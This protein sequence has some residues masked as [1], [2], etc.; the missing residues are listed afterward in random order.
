MRNGNRR[1]LLR[2]KP[3]R[4][5]P[6]PPLTIT[7]FPIRWSQRCPIAVSS[8]RWKP[9]VLCSMYGYWLSLIETLGW[10]GIDILTRIR[11]RPSTRISSFHQMLDGL[12]RAWLEIVSIDVVFGE[13]KRRPQHDLR[14]PDFDRAQSSGLKCPRA[15]RE[16]LIRRECSGVDRQIPQIASV[17]QDDRLHDAAV[18]VWL[19]DVRQ[20]QSDHAHVGAAGLTYGFGCPGN[21]RRRNRHHQLHRRIDLEDGLRFGKRLVAV[22]VARTDDGELQALVSGGE[23]LADEGD[24]L[25]LVGG[26]ERA[27]DDREFPAAAEEPRRLVGER[28]GDAL[29]RRLVDEEIARAGLGV[30]VPGEDAYA[31]LA[32]LAEHAR[33]AGAVLDRDRNYVDAAG[34]PVLHQLVLLRGVEARR[35]VPD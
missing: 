20:R 28:I 25:V 29:G 23:A 2:R 35:S 15:G 4:H 18:H 16:S 7:L 27:G 17:P 11:I 14:T 19:V 21:G 10:N 30:G 34:D 1:G 6:L 12:R 22:V 24:P 13:Q 3:L 9:V 26:G 5:V 33:D 31:A 32:R 8:E